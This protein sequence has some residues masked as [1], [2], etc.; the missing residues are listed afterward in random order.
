[1]INFY[2][3]IKLLRGKPYYLQILKCTF[4]LPLLLWLKLNIYITFGA[5]PCPSMLFLSLL[6]FSFGV[7]QL[8]L[9]KITDKSKIQVVQSN[10][11]KE[12]KL[13]QAIES[14]EIQSQFLM[15]K[16]GFIPSAL[17]LASLGL[18]KS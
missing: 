10:I 13:T 16:V 1:M 14:A 11:H 2:K 9:Q 8:V 18:R 4:L 5:S 6:C 17:C 15:I 3:V 7:G 12:L